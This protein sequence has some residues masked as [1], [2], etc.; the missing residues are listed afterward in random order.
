MKSP[1]V[2]CVGM[3]SWLITALASI[4]I[5]TCVA[6]QFDVFKTLFVMNNMPWIVMPAHYTIG[7]AGVISL[8][9]L[10][11]AIFFGC[12]CGKGSCPEC[13]SG[14]PKTPPPPFGA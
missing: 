10:L 2:R 14:S 8:S 7:L 11:M 13:G 5:G 9:M 4:N 12:K 1:L 3:L 6:F